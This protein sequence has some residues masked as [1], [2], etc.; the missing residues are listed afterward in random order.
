VPVFR[1]PNTWSAAPRPA[2]ALAQSNGTRSRVHSPAPRDRPPPPPRAAPCR[3]SAD[4][5]PR[6]H[7]PG[8]FASSPSRAGPARASPPPAPRDR[9]PPPPRAAPCR[10]PADRAPRGHRRDSSASSPSRAEP[11]RASALPAPRERPPPPRRDEPCALSL[12]QHFESSAEIH[13]RHRPAK[14]NPLARLLFQ[15]RL[16]GRHCLLEA[17]RAALPLQSC[18]GGLGLVQLGFELPQASQVIA[19]E[20]AGLR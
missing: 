9:P 7:C 2:W 10:S 4:R 19:R 1:S 12:A 5:A 13:L 20:C 8:Y 6:T 11:A 16:I 14:R 15:R 3:S 18:Q 17:S